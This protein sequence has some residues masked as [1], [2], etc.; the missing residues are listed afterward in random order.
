MRYGRTNWV[1][2]ASV[3]AHDIPEKCLQSFTC[4]DRCVFGARKIVDNQLAYEPQLCYECG[5][6]V[7]SCPAEAIILK[8]R[9]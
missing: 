6:C 9:S 1:R 7:T 5:L 4:V 8:E 2:K 3:I